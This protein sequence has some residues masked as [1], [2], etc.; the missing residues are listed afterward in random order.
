MH[1]F[2]WLIGSS[3]VL[4]TY[5]HSCGVAIHKPNPTPRERRTR[6]PASASSF[7]CCSRSSAAFFRLSYD[8][9][10]SLRIV[11]VSWV[12]GWWVS[13]RRNQLVVVYRSRGAWPPSIQTDTRP[14]GSPADDVRRQGRLAQGWGGSRH[15]GLAPAAPQVVSHGCSAACWLLAAPLA[16]CCLLLCSPI[17]VGCCEDEDVRAGRPMPVDAADN[18]DTWLPV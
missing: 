10:P 13:A 14:T 15:A 9:S 1:A 18:G 3:R 5:Q 8:R 7:T 11:R 4:P 6:S 12:G 2:I 16:A 17:G